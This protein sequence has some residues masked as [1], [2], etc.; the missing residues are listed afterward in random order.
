MT[1]DEIRNGIM[2][3][4]IKKLKEEPLKVYRTHSLIHIMRSQIN[5]LDFSPNKKNKIGFDCS[6][7]N[8]A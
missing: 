3:D 8:S 2:F 4:K 1:E 7:K 5:W 6:I